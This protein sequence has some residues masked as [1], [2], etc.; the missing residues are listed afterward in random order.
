MFLLS[1]I[2][3]LYKEIPRIFKILVLISIVF[4]LVNETSKEHI[5][6][7]KI[8]YISYLILFKKNEVQALFHSSSEVDGITLE[9]AFKLD[10][11][12]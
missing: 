1:K 9:F 5:V 7:E 12:I 3:P 4:L 8:L 6:L 10:I 11:K 2:R